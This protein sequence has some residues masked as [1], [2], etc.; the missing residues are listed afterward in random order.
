MKNKY[1]YENKPTPPAKTKKS[2]RRELQKQKKK[3]EIKKLTL[4][5]YEKS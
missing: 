5:L 1:I 3:P 2:Q 4:N